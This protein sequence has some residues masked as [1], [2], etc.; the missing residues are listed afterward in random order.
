MRIMAFI[1]CLLAL[2]LTQCT[3]RTKITGMQG[4]LQASSGIASPVPVESSGEAG[5]IQIKAPEGCLLIWARVK[6]GPIEDLE[7]ITL[8]TV[9]EASLQ[10]CT[11]ELLKGF[12]NAE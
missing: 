3:N 7:L 11:I 6:T 2:L 8:D 4:L 12:T 5:T 1:T 10:D 9:G